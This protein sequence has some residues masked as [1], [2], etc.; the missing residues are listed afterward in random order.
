MIHTSE[1]EGQQKKQEAI[2]AVISE[3]IGVLEKLV[4]FEAENFVG[5]WRFMGDGGEWKEYDK[6]FRGG[7]FRWIAS[8]W[9]YIG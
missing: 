3:K 8:Y 5:N 9:S 4:L 2:N 6:Q 7:F 1:L